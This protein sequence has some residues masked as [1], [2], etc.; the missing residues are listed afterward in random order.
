MQKILHLTSPPTPTEDQEQTDAQYVGPLGA[1]GDRPLKY[2]YSKCIKV[3]ATLFIV[4][5]EFIQ[6][7]IHDRN[8][9]LVAISHKSK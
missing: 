9:Y 5:R 4:T 1:K 2:R 3:E 6:T 8:F 7:N